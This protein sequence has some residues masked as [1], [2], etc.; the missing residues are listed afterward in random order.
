MRRLYRSQRDKKIF[1]LCGGLA[2]Q[3]NV[4]ATL[5]RLVVAAAA[6]FTGG[7]VI[8]LYIVAGLVIPKEPFG[9]YAG[10]HP[11]AGG[12]FGGGAYPGGGAYG[13]PRYN[14]W[15]GVSQ[16]DGPMGMGGAAYAQQPKYAAES[17]LDEVM[18]DLERKSMEKEIEA[19]KA[20][21]AQYEKQEKGEE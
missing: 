13:G 21:L 20:K 18:K 15:S 14:G 9:P 12:S 6:F 7:A 1:G 11:G 3:L 19:L 10:T 17:N 4:D 5:L 2:E 16:A 8:F